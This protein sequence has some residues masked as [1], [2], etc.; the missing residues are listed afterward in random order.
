MATRDPQ[1]AEL[2]RAFVALQLR[3]RAGVLRADQ[4]AVELD[5]ALEV[6]RSLIRMLS[7]QSATIRRIDLP[8][9]RPELESEPEAGEVA[10]PARIDWLASAAE[11]RRIYRFLALQLAGRR[12]FGTYAHGALLARLRRGQRGHEGRSPLEALFL[13]AEGVRIQQRVSLA[14]PG[15][16]PETAL[17]AQTLLSHWSVAPPPQLLDALLALAL[18]P[19]PLAA[20]PAWLPRALAERV[21]GA[22]APLRRGEA[23]VEQA[24]RVAERLMAWLSVPDAAEPIG[25]QA[26]AGLERADAARQ[27]FSELQAGATTAAGSEA[28]EPAADRSDAKNGEEPLGASSADAGDASAAQPPPSAAQLAFARLT[29]RPSGSAQTY[30]YD[31]WDHTIGGYRSRHCRVH[32][33]EAQ[34]DA[35]EFFDHTRRAYA[36]LLSDVRRQFERIRPER[37][38]PLRGLE[39]G[40]DLDLN[41]LT[42]ARIEARAHRTPTDRVYTARVRQTRDVATLFLLDMSASTEQPYVEPGDPPVRRIIDTLKEALVVM[43]TALSELGDSYAI[44]GFSSQGHDRVEV[45]PVKS[46]DDALSATVKT[47]IGGIAPK[48]GTRMGAALRHVVGKFSRVHAGSKHLILLSD[49]YPQDQEYGP[50]RRSRTYGIEDT[51]V[52]LREASAV[53]ITPFCIT[54]DR[55]GHDYLRDMCNPAQYLVIDE[56]EQLPR[57]LPKIYRRVVLG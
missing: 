9:L 39:D 48:S 24:I 29:A 43:S 28:A 49:G 16:A 34:H 4:S 1:A 56:L 10:L 47:R 46:F 27:L 21:L 8:S 26:D 31:E 5:D 19:Q 15:S 12:Q 2:E 17:L 14:Y 33:L 3:T 18:A 53:G 54:V 50:D 41:A 35:G 57:E 38:R 52:A 44:Y 55:A 25:A 32:E 20:V 42:E 36:A 45:Y 7:G 6:W 23:G 11:N 40:E 13:L 51:A 30:V 22:L 37:Y